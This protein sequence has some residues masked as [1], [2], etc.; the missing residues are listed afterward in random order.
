MG[1]DRAEDA[2][3]LRLYARRDLLRDELVLAP[4][5]QV[6]K[7]YLRVSADAAPSYVCLEKVVDA[8]ESAPTSNASPRTVSWAAYFHDEA[9]ER[10]VMWSYDPGPL[11]PDNWTEE[12]DREYPESR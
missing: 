2:G 3:G 12:R 1:G 6:D 5:G 11:R 7:A 9:L 8:L 10:H 4:S